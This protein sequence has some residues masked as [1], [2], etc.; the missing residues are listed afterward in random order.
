MAADARRLAGAALAAALRDSARDDAGADVDQSDDAGACRSRPA[1]TRS[2]GSS[3]TSPGSPSSGSCA[4]RTPPAPTASSTRR[5][6]RDRR[7]RRDLRFGPAR[8]W[9]ALARRAAVA[10][11]AGRSGSRRSS[12]PAS[13]RSRATSDRRRR[14]LLPPPRAFPRGHARRG[15]RLVARH[16]RPARACR[17]R[18][19]AV[20]ADAGP[21]L[22]IAGGAIA[23]GRA[24][25]APGFS[26]DN[27][28]PAADGAARRRSRSTPRR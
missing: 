3:A 7:A 23:L 2:R 8:P 12:T 14:A 15:V 4:A 11:R 19:D 10:R 13:T 1:S 18:R 17:S 21:P 27:E 24:P 26:F 16:A 28:L 25:T 9:R 6:R 22:Q 5:S 20:A